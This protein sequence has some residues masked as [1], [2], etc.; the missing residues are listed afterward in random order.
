[1]TNPDEST[2]KN[3]AIKFDEDNRT[4]KQARIEEDI[5]QPVNKTTITENEK[6][7]EAFLQPVKYNSIKEIEKKS[8]TI[9]QP[10][11]YNS[12]KE[13]KIKNKKFNIPENILLIRIQRCFRKFLQLKEKSKQE[14]SNVKYN[15]HRTLRTI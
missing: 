5:A 13:I 8:E 12:I 2:Q 9:L 1:M 6:K 4:Y 7:A 14:T 10:L 11:K 3:R 15:N